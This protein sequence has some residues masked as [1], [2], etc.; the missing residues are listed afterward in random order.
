MSVLRLL[1]LLLA[2]LLAAVSAFGQELCAGCNSMVPGAPV[3][4]QWFTTARA[5]R[6]SF[7]RRKG[8][9]AARHTLP[10]VSVLSPMSPQDPE[11]DPYPAFCRPDPRRSRR[12]TPNKCP[13]QAPAQALQSPSSYILSNCPPIINYVYG[14]KI[15]Q[16]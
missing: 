7:G 2:T 9:P 13:S 4:E 5:V 14:G 3:G 1:F 6:L 12:F 15:I 16:K 8:T 10:P 11:S